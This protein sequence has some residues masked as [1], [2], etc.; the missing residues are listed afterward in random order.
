MFWFPSSRLN[1][2]FL[3]NFLSKLVVCSAP[4]LTFPFMFLAFLSG[5]I[6]KA[7]VYG[8]LKVTDPFY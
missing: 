3:L 6:L 5:P 2:L 1:F 8:F 4:W 7:G